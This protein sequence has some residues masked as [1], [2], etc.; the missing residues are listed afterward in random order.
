MK[1]I[2]LLEQNLFKDVDNLYLRNYFLSKARK[3]K[4]IRE[5]LQSCLHLKQK[6]SAWLKAAET[7]LKDWS[8]HSQSL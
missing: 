8:K 2:K 1:T 4:V 3:P 6:A 7:I 5:M